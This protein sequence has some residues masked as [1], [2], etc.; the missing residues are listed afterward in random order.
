[1]GWGLRL[2][3]SAV[4]FATPG[5]R[6]FHVPFP[7]GFTRAQMIERVALDVKIAD[8]ELKTQKVVLSSAGYAKASEHDVVPCFGKGVQK[9]MEGFLFPSEYAFDV[10]TLGANIVANQISAFCGEWSK[11]DLSY[12]R[13]KNLTPYDVL[14]IASMVE[15]EAALPGDRPKIAAVIYNRLRLRIPLGIDATLRYGLKIPPDKSITEAELQSDNPYN[16]RKF[17]GLPPT[18]IGNPGFPSLKAAAHPVKAGWLYYARVPNTNP[19]QQKFF[20]SYSAYEKFLAANGY[21]PH[22]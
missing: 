19:P 9:N 18:P 17:P 16:T 22:P 13:S 10:T 6:Q 8:R 7:E 3:L 20:E 2:V 5:L 11:L 1:M 21:G 4:V 14:K 15:E 12:A